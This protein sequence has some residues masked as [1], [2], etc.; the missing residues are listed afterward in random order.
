MAKIPVGAVV[1]QTFNF[2]F[3]GFLNLLRVSWLPQLII[4]GLL[5]FGML[6]V[7]SDVLAAQSGQPGATPPGAAVALLF[8]AYLVIMVMIC[9]QM[10]AVAQTALSPSENGGWFHLPFGEPVWRL[11]GAYILFILIFVGAALGMAFA[12]FLLGATI[13]GASAT[14]GNGVGAAIALIAALVPLMIYALFIFVAVRL[15]ALLTPVVVAEKSI[16]LRRSWTL[17]RGNF[18][19]LFAIFLLVFLP[20]MAVEMVAIFALMPSLPVMQPGMAPE[21]VQAAILGWEAEMSSAMLA[22]SYVV[23]PFLALFSVLFYGAL[24]GAQCFA[25]RALVQSESEADAF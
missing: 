2:T 10:V 13:G 11:I 23:I 17:T 15:G 18:W 5:A 21:Q 8:P 4:V 3:G 19:R 20:F 22:Y 14:A 24:I 16:G 1:A 6:P 7:M 25:Y 12:G 9:S